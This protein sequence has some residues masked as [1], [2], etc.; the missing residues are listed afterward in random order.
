[1]VAGS[2]SY[3]EIQSSITSDTS[4]LAAIDI[5]NPLDFITWLQHTNKTATHLEFTEGYNSYLS[6]WYSSKETKKSEIPSNIANQYIELLKEISLKYST[7]AER[8]FLSNVNYDDPTDIDVILPFFTSKIKDICQYFSDKR[9]VVKS[10]VHRNKHNGTNS[11]LEKTIYSIV[12]DLI[13]RDD[14]NDYDTSNIILSSIQSN[15]NIE[16]EEFF[17]LYDSYYDV[18][19]NDN[20]QTLEYPLANTHDI[21]YNLFLNFDQAII[22]EMKNRLTFLKSLGFNNFSINHKFRASELSYLNDSDFINLIGDGDP[23]NLTLNLKA[24]KLKKY[25]GTDYYYLSTGSTNSS[26]VSGILIEADN[27]TNNILNRNYITTA[28]SQSDDIK[29]LR[30]VGLFFKP[31]NMGVLLFN[32]PSKTY[33]VNYQSLSANTVYIFPDPNVYES[34]EM[35]GENFSPFVYTITLGRQIYDRGNNYLFGFINKSSKDSDFYAYLSKDQTYYKRLDTDHI[36][37]VSPTNHMSIVENKGTMIDWKNDVFGNEFGLFKPTAQQSLFNLLKTLGI[38]NLFDAGSMSE[39]FKKLIE[40]GIIP[41]GRFI[42]VNDINRNF[43]KCLMIDGYAF[44]D[45]SFTSEYLDLEGY[46]FDYSTTNTDYFGF[47]RTG[48]SANAVYPLSGN[49]TLAN[50]VAATF[51][52]TNAENIPNNTDTANTANIDAGYFLKD[53]YYL[54]D[55]VS[56]TLKICTIEDGVFFTEN[57]EGVIMVEPQSS[58]DPLWNKNSTLFYYDYINEGSINSSSTHEMKKPSDTFAANYSDV[59]AVLRDPFDGDVFS[60]RCLSKDEQV[61]D[62]GDYEEPEDF[63]GNGGGG[64][65]TKYSIFGNLRGVFQN[66]IYENRTAPG[67]FYVRPSGTTYYIPGSAALWDTFNR[68]SPAIKDELWDGSITNIEVVYDIIFIETTNYFVFDKLNYNS[69]TN[70]FERS[71]YPINQISK[72]SVLG[73]SDPLAITPLSSQE[74]HYELVGSIEKISNIFFHEDTN[75]IYFCRMRLLSSVDYGHSTNYK[76]I[77]PEIYHINITNLN[78]SKVYPLF[79]PN[80]IDLQIFSL[81]G[82]GCNI[83]IDEIE[84]PVFTYNSHNLK[85]N[86]SYICKDLNNTSFITSINMKFDEGKMSVESANFYKPDYYNYTDNFFQ[87]DYKCTLGYSV[88]NDPIISNS[89]GCLIF[90]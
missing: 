40:L 53:G 13:T 45:R 88:G 59:L 15:L 33:E 80:P 17:D 32:A 61:K 37:A 16:I 77:Y 20:T 57:E 67:S 52:G 78:V 35:N 25:A 7:T 66:L 23:D 79:T 85:Y 1:M 89:K 12:I 28:S 72:S 75:D 8:R 4:N 31:D 46:N 9:E 60:A 68:Y 6:L 84:R 5:D 39:L 58:D 49:L 19:P 41:G 55:K 62:G 3:F 14:Q 27:N 24:Q 81:S 21:D 29:S 70:L 11:G 73:I 63:V 22:S 74:F 10:V 42:G 71:R 86:I 64:N 48:L 18:N 43:N 76:I 50:G 90:N 2:T 51:F 38:N 44:F 30:D 47:I 69:T 56:S 34:I 83:W 36:A 26:Y 82:S 87:T 54:C 65:N